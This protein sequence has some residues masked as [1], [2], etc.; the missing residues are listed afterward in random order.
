MSYSCVF[1]KFLLFKKIIT[2]PAGVICSFLFSNYPIN[3]FN[4]DYNLFI[5]TG[6]QSMNISKI[7]VL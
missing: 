3:D 4:V 5:S 7:N 1:L 6:S 2:F